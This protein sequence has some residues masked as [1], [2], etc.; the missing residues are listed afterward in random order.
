M[1]F[2]GS[3]KKNYQRAAFI[4]TGVDQKKWHETHAQKTA[5]K[6]GWRYERLQGEP[7]LLQNLLTQEATDRNILRVTPH[8]I[9]FFDSINHRLD[10]AAV[11]SSE[12][13][14]FTKDKS[15]PPTDPHLNAE[16]A[17][18]R[19]GLGI[20]A[21]GTYTDAVIY[22]LKT[23]T[24]VCKNKALT[25]RWDFCV[26]VKA[27]LDGL[28]ADLLQQVELAA[29]STT[30]ATNAI[31]EGVGQ[32][33][34][35][36]LM[37]PY[38]VSDTDQADLQPKAI[39]QGRLEISGKEIEP[40]NLDEI[41]QAARH[42]VERQRVSAFAVSGFA[43]SINP[44]H[45]LMVKEMILAETGLSV[46]CGHELSQQLD[47]KTRARTAVLNARII[48]RL[49]K[50]IKEIEMV[51]RQMGILA[52]MV[53]VKGDGS[54]ISANVARNRPVETILSGPSASVTGAHHLTQTSDAVVVD[55]GGTTTD[56]AAIK[57]N[58]VPVLESGTTVG[59][60]HTHVMALEMQ[61]CG[62]GGDS[63]IVWHKDALFIGPQRV[64]PVAWLGHQTNQ[65]QKAFSFVESRINYYHADTRPMTLLTANESKSS[66]ELTPREQIIHRLLT[67][68]PYSMDELARKM[69]LTYWRLLPLER[70]EEQG[71]IQR[72][73]LTPS[74]LLHVTGRF[75]RWDTQSAQKW[76]ELLRL[77]MPDKE[78]T[79]AEQL[80][81][82]VV[83]QMAVEILKSRLGPIAKTNAKSDH[84]MNCDALIDNWL[85]GGNDDFHTQL[86]LKHPIIGI[87]APAEHFIPQIGKLLNTQ[88]IIPVD[89]DVANAIGAITSHVRVEQQISIRPDDMGRFIIEGIEG[90]LTFEDFDAACAFSEKELRRKILSLGRIA[91]T[92]QSDIEIQT[93]DRIVHTA[94]GSRLFLGRT[95]TA[96]IEGRPD[97]VA[98]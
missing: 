33:V 12:R 64:A 81:S 78:T 52:P 48:P 5:Q 97:L 34:G 41:R 56:I 86:T 31:V 51:L 73:G 89:A 88:T 69:E 23:N 55:I 85:A 75:E 42:M 76:H 36:L 38:G 79:T 62:L 25:T 39:I 27:V 80:L 10:S 26:G 4:D 95:L 92:S 7:G 24:L 8:H 49:D 61:T 82:Q 54:L 84:C 20:D 14:F 11:Q 9:T 74:D 83:Q 37:P 46:T 53:V 98:K 3:W 77:I 63:A 45:E 17:P 28:D 96:Q 35:L 2:L 91:G 87:G 72:C 32:K 68:R 30:M 16:P 66:L 67:E 13:P 6:Y 22:D 43:G 58:R 40:V 1:T 50:L 29:I 18:Y 21:G 59:G 15:N 19:Y 65:L 47:F 57:N 44:A 70:L 94:D 90:A 71:L 93:D 60:H